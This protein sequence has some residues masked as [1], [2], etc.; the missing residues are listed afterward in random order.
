MAAAKQD[1]YEILGVSKTA[2][3]EDLKKAYRVLA[4]KHHPDR[5]P[6]NQA[7]EQKFKEIN[8]AYDIL[9]DE[10][11]RAAYDQF[12]HAAFQNGG[13]RSGRPNGQGAEG[14]GFAGGGFADIFNE[15]FGDFTDS[16]AGGRQ[17]RGTDL[18]YNMEIS[19]EEAFSGKQVT[20]RVPGSSVCDTCHGSG[21][22]Q[23]SQPVTCPSCRGSGKQRAAQGFFTIERTCQQCAGL[24][25]IIE[26]PCR[27]CRGNGTVKREKTLEVN[28]PAGVED[29]SRIRLSGQGEAG[30]RGLP[31]GDLYIFVNIRQH[32]IF[33]R[34][35]ATIECQIPIPLVTAVLGG[36]VD[37][38]TVEGNWG[39]VTIPA[40]TQS[41]QKFRLKNKGMSVLRSSNRGDMY[42]TVVTETP[43][44]LTKR[45]Q[46][47]LK[48]FTEIAEANPKNY[49]IMEKFLTKVKEFWKN[50]RP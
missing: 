1:Y 3:G 12:G 25:K 8:E 5:N 21:S 6:G 37:V 46:E 16:R 34:E 47:L 44:N 27:V 2:S 36:S 41:G 13:G 7:S 24:G 31:A 22:E 35:G 29:G 11:K 23:G 49:P 4:M 10:Q 32:P 43:V 18:R 40:G 19:L 15:M 33:Q 48:E 50:L 17:A 28:I 38:P 9:K 45:Q 14:F 20:I 39:K 42:C 26:K 30:M